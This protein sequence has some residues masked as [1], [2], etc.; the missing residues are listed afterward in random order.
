MRSVLRCRCLLLTASIAM[1]CAR[2]NTR[3]RNVP[4][5]QQQ[6]I[7]ALTGADQKRLRDQRAV[8]EAYLGSEE[9]KKKYQ[10]AAG[11]LGTIR[12]VLQARVFKREQTYELQCLGIVLGDAFVQ[13][14]GM[15]W[16]MVED[17]YG[18]DPA[19]RMPGTTVILHPLT[20]ISKRVERGEQVD[21]FDLFNGI[22]AQVEDLERKGQQQSM[23][24]QPPTLIAIEHDDYHAQH[25]GR[26]ADGRQFFV[27]TPFLPAMTG[28][29]GREFLAVYL[30][31]PQ[32]SLV[33]AR[34][35][36][37]GE[38]EPL[39][40]TRSTELLERRLAELGP[41]EY[42][43]IEVKPFQLERFG[44]TFGLVPR[45]PDE[46]ADEEGWSVEAQPGNY[47]SFYEPWDSGE[48]DT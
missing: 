30:F 29:A 40:D 34:I 10:T 44:T 14:L 6:K 45:P 35:D 11:K 36:D 15:E 19:V 28:K 2:T 1:G 41:V 7:T 18:R 12:A 48:Y 22:T 9:S 46:E 16:I 42:G 43:R 37:L 38:R 32:G 39:D 17:E 3:E 8:I 26:T 25:V 21:V 31:D 24:S 23:K 13:D 5:E 20:M 47:M 4:H 33:E 27:T